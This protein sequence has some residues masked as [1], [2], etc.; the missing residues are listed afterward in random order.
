MQKYSTRD[1]DKDFPDDDACL[2]WLFNQ[3]W[4]NGVSCAKCERLTKHYRITGRPVYSCEF[5]GTHLAP[6]AGTIFQGTKLDHLRLWFKAIAY[7][8]VTRCG[9]SS[10]QLSRVLGVTVKTG[11]RMFKKIR[12]ILAESPDGPLTG[13]VEVDET[14]VGGARRGKRGCGAEGKTIVMGMVERKGLVRAKI[15]PNVR[16]HTL[17]PEIEATVSKDAILY[18]DDLHSYRRVGERGYTNTPSP[19]L[20]RSMYGARTSTRTR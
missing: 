14:Y 20:R 7:M 18:T 11:Y 12:E 15:V 16:A 5:C 4:P 17:I 19:T 2:E 1:F 6:M 9:I 10:R 13:S 8:A 3:R